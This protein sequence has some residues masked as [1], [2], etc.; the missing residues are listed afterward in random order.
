MS[1]SM[2]NRSM[3]LDQTNKDILEHLSSGLTAKEIAEK[4]SV[5]VPMIKKRTRELRLRTNSKNN[6]ELACWWKENCKLEL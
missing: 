2:K 6:V 3:K 5:S 4:I 1:Y